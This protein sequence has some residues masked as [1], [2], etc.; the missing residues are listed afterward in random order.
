MHILCAIDL[1]PESKGVGDVAAAIARKLNLPLH[2]LHCAP[3]WVVVGE[4]PVVEPDEGPARGQFAV[5]AER[6]RA[7]SR[8]RLLDFQKLKKAFPA[9]FHFLPIRNTPLIYIPPMRLL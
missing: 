4:L 1:S 3:D 6:L 5:E 8:R 2:L 7:T 9:H